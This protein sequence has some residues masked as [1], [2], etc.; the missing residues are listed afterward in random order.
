MTMAII[1]LN[2][3]LAA[4]DIVL[5]YVGT[6]I[7]SI[8]LSFIIQIFNMLIDVV[9]PKLNW[10]NPSAAMKRNTNTLL[11]MLITIGTVALIIAAGVL[12]LPMRIETILVFSAVLTVAAI[13]L[14]KWFLNYAPKA[15]R[16]RF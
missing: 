13:L 10:E 3:P 16:R 14:W 4:K 9:N 15:L 11:A 8:V 7:F 1:Y 12:L 2:V 5:T 6:I